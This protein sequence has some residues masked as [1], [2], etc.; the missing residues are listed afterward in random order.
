M[1]K[2]FFSKTE[3]GTEYRI[4]L[5]TFGD[6]E[7]P[8]LVRS[9]LDAADGVHGELVD[10]INENIDCLNDKVLGL[11]DSIGYEN[12]KEIMST[13]ARHMVIM[14]MKDEGWTLYFE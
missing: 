6:G 8:T 11:A 4:Y 13:V 9:A 1:S 10:Y 14:K 5:Y 12:A 7:F 2:E 3:N